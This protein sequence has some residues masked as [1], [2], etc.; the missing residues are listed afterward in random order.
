MQPLFYS[1]LMRPHT[2]FSFT[3]LFLLTLLGY[4]LSLLEF[5]VLSYLFFS[6]T[7]FSALALS[8]SL[9]VFLGLLFWIKTFSYNLESNYFLG[10]FLKIVTTSLLFWF[11]T[12]MLQ[13]L[14]LA[15]A[16]F[17]VGDF[18][19]YLFLSIRFF[20]VCLLFWGRSSVLLRLFYSSV[21]SGLN[22][23]V[24]FILPLSSIFYLKLALLKEFFVLVLATTMSYLSFG[25]GKP[26]FL[27]N[28]SHVAFVAFFGL[29]FSL[30]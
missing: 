13:P 26:S 27:E 18:L 4:F 16:L 5:N 7:F 20:I 9:M 30:I 19:T 24:V 15:L 12:S 1:T 29:S 23:Y 17:F 10:N 8:I 22:F 25:L 3:S 6:Q 2:L 28:Y 14:L 11:A 21:F